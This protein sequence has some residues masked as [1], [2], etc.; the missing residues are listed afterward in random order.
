MRRGLILAV[1]LLLVVVLAASLRL[2]GRDGLGAS[3][4]GDMARPLRDE[5]LSRDPDL[6][7]QINAHRADATVLTV[8]SWDK[9][10][11]IPDAAR[12]CGPACAPG[13][14]AR[15]V[16]IVHLKPGGSNKHVILN[17]GDVVSDDDIR[18]L[19]SKAPEVACLADILQVE[20]SG[21][22]GAPHGE[23]CIGD[24][25]EAPGGVQTRLL[26]PWQDG[27]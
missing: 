1:L 9:M 15:L 16:R 26:Y 27:Y 8:T 10:P 4:A 12:I 25:L 2:G 11:D 24:P 18:D 6:Y 5:L 3:V 22:R 20:L 19:S 17:I 23:T 14:A 21:L 13:S 7:V